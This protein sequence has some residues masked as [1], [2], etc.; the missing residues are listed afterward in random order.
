MQLSRWPP[1]VC[2]GAAADDIIFALPPFIPPS[3]AAR[4]GG[5]AGVGASAISKP[6]RSLGPRVSTATATS[7]ESGDRRFVRDCDK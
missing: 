4:G 2:S 3:L 5:S 6:P 1:Y 7:E